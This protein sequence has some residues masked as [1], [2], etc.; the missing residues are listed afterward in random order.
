MIFT[1]SNRKNRTLIW[2][3]LPPVTSTNLSQGLP[4]LPFASLAAVS[5]N[6]GSV[7]RVTMDDRTMPECDFQYEVWL[8]DADQRCDLQFERDLQAVCRE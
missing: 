5:L 8:N 4:L 1:V 6:R 3:S 7:R 2:S